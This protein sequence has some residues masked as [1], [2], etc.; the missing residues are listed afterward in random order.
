MCQD[1]S[2][3][4][5]SAESCN[6]GFRFSSRDP[7]ICA[8]R[9]SFAPSCSSDFWARVT[10][11][12]VISKTIIFF[13]FIAFAGNIFRSTHAHYS[14]TATRTIELSLWRLSFSSPRSLPRPSSPIKTSRTVGCN[15]GFNVLALSQVQNS[16]R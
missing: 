16:L 10:F 12:Q 8:K 11:L 1:R 9:A 7:L 15:P 6:H 5:C 3:R 14:T 2:H 4:C 13:S